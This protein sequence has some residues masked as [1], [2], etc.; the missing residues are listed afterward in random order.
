MTRNVILTVAAGYGLSQIEAFLSSWHEHAAAAK[1]II[2]TYNCDIT[3]HQ[4]CGRLGVE[5]VELTEPW[6]LSLLVDRHFVF[7][8]FLASCP[9]DFRDVLITDAR[10]VIFQSDPFLAPRDH[11]VSF[12][13]E[14]EVISKCNFNRYWMAHVYGVETAYLLGEETI[15]CAGTTIGTYKG[16]LKYLQLMCSEATA[17]P[18]A[19]RTFGDQASH[20]YILYQLQ[21]PFIALDR[22]DRIVQTLS[23]TSAARITIRSDQVWVDGATAPMVHQWDRHPN[24]VA[25]IGSRYR[26]AE[27]GAGREALA[28]EPPSRET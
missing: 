20:N 2:F 7:R 9:G 16:V 8:D 12:A 19:V 17:H 1:L 5:T 4:A 23:H 13:A 24:L 15:A 26:V 3:L 6:K 11:E 25:Y 27:A 10:D 14:D 28:A 21:P 22:Y 18:D